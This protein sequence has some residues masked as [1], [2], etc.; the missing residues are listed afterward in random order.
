MSSSLDATD[1]KIDDESIFDLSDLPDI[2]K[3]FE[4]YSS[5]LDAFFV[6]WTRGSQLDLSLSSIVAPFEK[7]EPNELFD[8]RDEKR[9]KLLESANYSIDSLRD[10]HLV[11]FSEPVIVSEL[12]CTNVPLD[13]T[14]GA[15]RLISHQ[16]LDKKI[17]AKGPT[18]RASERDSR[19]TIY[20]INDLVLGIILPKKCR[21]IFIRFA[22]FKSLLSDQKKLEE[23]A[24]AFHL[25]KDVP[26]VAKDVIEV[27][28]AKVNTII[29]SK[30]NQ[31]RSVKD[32]Y[33]VSKEELFSNQSNLEAIKEH[34]ASSNERLR[35]INDEYKKMVNEALAKSA[36]Y[37]ELEDKT[38]YAEEKFEKEESRLKALTSQNEEL[39]STLRAIKEELAEANREKN[40]TSLDIVGH[41]NETSK[42]LKTYYKLSIFSFLALVCTAFYV[43]LNGED[44]TEI[45]PLLEDVSAWDILISRLPLIAATTLIIGGLS[46]TFFYLVKH[47]VSLNT[48]KMTMLKASILAEQITNS[49]DCELLGE[50]KMLEFKRDTKIKLIMEVFSNSREV[51]NNNLMIEVLKALNPK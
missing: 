42:Q 32:R 31:L 1:S 21:L 3:S 30:M 50:H 14:T 25:A 4:D 5:K 29:E 19:N 7:F 27:K 18:R 28:I 49:L 43:Y 33:A 46:G 45:L 23:L 26:L 39:N 2:E 36:Q 35:L 24:T 12:A 13:A 40:L 17:I 41:S 15:I 11:L 6:M 10:E 44:F 48:E 37:D 9:L 20:I 16:H 51:P 22:R 38:K 47:I 8:N 34:T